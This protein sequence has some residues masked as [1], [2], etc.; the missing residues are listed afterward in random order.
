M[1]LSDLASLVESPGSV[2]VASALASSVRAHSALRSR[3]C[4]LE[5]ENR[6]LR[7]DVEELR[8]R[9]A[10]AEVAGIVEQIVA[11]ALDH[12]AQ[13]Q[14]SP[15]GSGKLNIREVL[16]TSS[17]KL[18]RFK[19]ELGNSLKRKATEPKPDN[20]ETR[21]FEPKK[22]LIPENGD[23]NETKP[24]PIIRFTKKEHS[25]LKD[26][27]YPPLKNLA[28]KETPL[29]KDLPLRDPPIT[30]SKELP[31]SI[32]KE[33]PINLSKELPIAFSKD[34]PI[35]L[36]K[37]LPISLSKDLPINL[38]KELPISL[39][40]DLPIGLSKEIPLHKDPLLK[41]LPLK[42]GG[43]K[44]PLALRD[45]P[46][47]REAAVL[48][49]PIFN[50]QNTKKVGVSPYELTI[51]NLSFATDCKREQSVQK[52]LRILEKVSID[53]FRAF[54]ELDGLFDQVLINEFNTQARIFELCAGSLREDAHHFFIAV[55][56]RASGKTFTMQGLPVMPGLLPSF[57][58]NLDFSGPGVS[59]QIFETKGPDFADLLADASP[60]P[61]RLGQLL[62]ALPVSSPS[63][64]DVIYRKVLLARRGKTRR[65]QWSLAIRL[66]LSPDQSFTFIDA[67]ELCEPAIEE[68]E[69][70]ANSI[71]FGALSRASLLESLL[72]EG[73]KPSTPQK[74][75]FFGHL[76]TVEDTPAVRLLQRVLAP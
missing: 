50:A 47:Y 57:S 10:S 62:T 25:N 30:F 27:A 35:N 43:F 36:S 52:I 55:G 54:G 65:H 63:E 70:V 12:V 45:L 64:L 66:T 1:R 18:K 41:D 74:F 32:S 5:S 21:E 16:K 22:L 73:L 71:R 68:N 76:A 7:A 53:S 14:P 20:E 75:Y 34:L 60:K 28:P 38:S 44:D 61:L 39:S 29:Y 67:A 46:L 19:A 56:A 51:Q 59:V 37:E 15:A 42:E 9:L 17:G 24:A 33:L 13:P 69:F 72:A 3:I 49:S 58:R 2:E 26:F 4:L 23:K 40:K 11:R 6:R 8:G 48:A 31:I